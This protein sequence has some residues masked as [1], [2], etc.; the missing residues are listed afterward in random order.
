MAASLLSINLIKQRLI[1]DSDLGNIHRFRLKVV[2]VEPQHLEQ[3]HI[4][5]NISFRAMGK[6]GKPKSINGQ[7]P[8]YAIGCFVETVAF[9]RY[10]RIAG[11][12]DGLRVNDDQGRPLRFF[13]TCLRICSCKVF[14]SVSNT[15]AARHCL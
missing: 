14:I 3:P 5:C 4:V 10:T 15:P 9:G 11:I 7:M 12:L 13:F 1:E 6:E 2:D 8:F